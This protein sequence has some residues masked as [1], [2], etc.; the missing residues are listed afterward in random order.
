MDGGENIPRQKKRPEKTKTASAL[1][2]K[3]GMAA[4]RITAS[5]RGR[6][7]ERMVELAAEN[8][9]PV[10]ED[11]VLAEILAES[12]V[13]ACVPEQTYRAVAVVF[14]FL[15]RAKKEGWF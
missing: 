13:G 11:A 10:V 5:G 3:Q 1:S 2:Y 14:S 15:E 6:T 12:P 4:P 9:V 8:N 7:A